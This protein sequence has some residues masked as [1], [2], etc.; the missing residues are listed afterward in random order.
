[1]L[2]DNKKTYKRIYYCPICKRKRK[3]E[4]LTTIDLAKLKCSKGHSFESEIGLMQP[5]WE[6]KI[7]YDR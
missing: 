3:M 7:T 5:I 4:V 2:T 6:W 1:M